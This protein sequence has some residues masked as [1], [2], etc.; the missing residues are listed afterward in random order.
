MFSPPFLPPP[1]ATGVDIEDVDVSGIQD[2][3]KC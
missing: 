3:D 2:D 1:W